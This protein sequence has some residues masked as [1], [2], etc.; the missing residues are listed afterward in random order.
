MFSHTYAA[1]WYLCS[2]VKGAC[3]APAG[4][5]AQICSTVTWAYATAGIVPSFMLLKR[6][7]TAM[8][9]DIEAPA[10]RP[11]KLQEVATMLKGVSELCALQATQSANVHGPLDTDALANRVRPDN[12]HQWQSLIAPLLSA[13]QPVLVNVLRRGDAGSE[14]V[15]ACR[16]Q[17]VT[18]MLLRNSNAVVWPRVL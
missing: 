2:M 17:S 8:V 7:C 4:S 16:R 15:R 13:A 3:H 11:V 14:Q 18:A 10:G 12:L 6:L 5:M 1:V 9:R